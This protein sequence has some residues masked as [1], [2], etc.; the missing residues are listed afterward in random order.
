LEN[1]LPRV[2]SFRDNFYYQQQAELNAGN[3][4][5]QHT[6]IQELRWSEMIVNFSICKSQCDHSWLQIFWTWITFWEC[7]QNQIADK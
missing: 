4:I 7:T 3:V 6:S 1:N 2:L 5:V